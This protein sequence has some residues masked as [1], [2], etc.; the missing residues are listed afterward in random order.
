MVAQSRRPMRS[1]PPHPF[2]ASDRRRMARWLATVI[3]TTLASV[4]LVSLMA[5]PADAA[6]PDAGLFGSAD[7]TYDGAY[8]Q[9][10]A[11]LGL[12]ATGTALPPQAVAWLASQQCLDGSFEAYRVSIRTAC[13]APDPANFTGPDSNSTALAAMALRSAGKVANAQR[14]IDALLSSQNQ[15]G[16]WGYILSSASDANSTGLVLAALYGAAGDR[17]A[18]A[19]QRARAY[20]AT[21]QVA[22]TKAGDYGLV[23]PPSP[24]AN[25]L[26][27]GQALIGIAGTDV[28][29][30]PPTR[31]GS[32]AGTTCASS[33]KA[34]VAVY[35]ED[36]LVR[37]G[38]RIPS[39]MEPTETDWNVTASAVI[40]LAAARLGRSGVR[41]GLRALQAHATQYAFKDGAAVPAA[42]GALLLVADATGADP[43]AFGSDRLNVTRTLL[44]SMRA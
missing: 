14:A 12:A 42:L 28:P 30:D 20:L 27:S 29:F 19:R 22:C 15:D 34:K 21:Q 13:Q 23:Y 16:G 7:P 40:G 6:S 33:M 26:A 43:R 10:V 17:V 39:P 37:N 11:L 25:A 24:Q 9:S 38:G 18:S 31:Y 2:P 5:A 8:R 44:A 1:L 36:L 3:A 4:S 35:L 32:L 41:A